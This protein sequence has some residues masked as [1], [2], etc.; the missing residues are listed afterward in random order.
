M[1][2]ERENVLRAVSGYKSFM[3]QWGDEFKL[4]NSFVR[5]NVCEE[6]VELLINDTGSTGNFRAPSSFWSQMGFK[7]Q[8]D[9]MGDDTHQ[10]LL[11]PKQKKDY[12]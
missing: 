9:F 8:F 12:R 2:F 5:F 1:N 10:L 6:D 7:L 11:L 3:V 4:D